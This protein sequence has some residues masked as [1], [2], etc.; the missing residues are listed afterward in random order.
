MPEPTTYEIVLRGHPS[1][2]LLRPLLDDFT[3]DNSADIV[4]R[5]VGDVCDPA[6]LHGILVHLTAVNLEI[7]SIAPHQ[8]NPTKQ[9]TDMNITT[10]TTAHSG[11]DPARPAA[12][13]ALPWLW[14][15]L[16][17]IWLAVVIV[18]ELPAWTLAIWI[19]TTVGSVTMLQA[20]LKRA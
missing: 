9:G 11:D 2:R 6:H 5:V 16:T 12:L 10:E 19:A 1:T 17:A 15:A 3:I 18:A 14:L 13:R 20:R 8:P 7:I 4:T